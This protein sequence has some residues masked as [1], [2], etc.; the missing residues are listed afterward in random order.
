M[1]RRS[2]MRKS[3]RKIMRR[4][5]KERGEVRDGRNGGGERGIRELE[6]KQGSI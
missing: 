6:R 4:I 3:K 5:V 2:G 1:R